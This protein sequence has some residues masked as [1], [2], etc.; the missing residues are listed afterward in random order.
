MFSS[1]DDL[2]AL[3]KECKYIFDLYDKDPENAHIMEDELTRSFIQYISSPK[4]TREKIVIIK[5]ASSIIMN[6]LTK[7]R[8][9][10]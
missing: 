3:E 8:E 7:P 2:G 5:N 10:I 6:L 1:F 4:T 9:M